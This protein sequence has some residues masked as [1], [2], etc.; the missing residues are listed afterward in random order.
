MQRAPK[1]PRLVRLP[2]PSSATLNTEQELLVIVKKIW[3]LEPFLPK[4][5][6]GFPVLSVQ[7]PIA[8]IYASLWGDAS[9]SLF[10]LLF[11]TSKGTTL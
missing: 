4:L 7:T 11:C 10:L 6:P 5:L 8:F 9:C 3:V 2:R 1:P